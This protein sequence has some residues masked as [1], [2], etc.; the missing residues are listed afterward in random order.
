MVPTL[1]APQIPASAER[2]RPAAVA[3]AHLGLYET[4]LRNA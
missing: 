4:V 3:A 2:H 1:P